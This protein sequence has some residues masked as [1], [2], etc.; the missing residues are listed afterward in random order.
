MLTLVCVVVGDG[1]PFPVEI[2]ADQSVG[3]LK[4]KIKATNP[5]SILCV[6]KD[7]D[8]YLAL[9]DNAWLESTN[10]LT[11]Q[12]IKGET[13]DEMQNYLGKVM[14]MNPFSSLD[15]ALPTRPGQ[16]QLHTLVVVP[17]R[18]AIPSDIE[19]SKKR[20]LDDLAKEISTPSLFANC[21][22]RNSWIFQLQKFDGQIQ[23]HRLPP[24]D[25]RSLLPLVLLH[26]TFATFDA[27]CKTIAFGRRDCD[28][29]VAFCNAMSDQVDAETARNMLES[30]L[31]CDSTVGGSSVLDKALYVAVETGDGGGDPTMY[32]LANYIQ[33]L[34]HKIDRAMPCYLV[35]IC[36]PLLSVF[37]IVNVAD[38]FVLCEP[39]VTSIPLL[40][41]D[42]VGL[43]TTGVRVFASLK[44]ALQDLTSSYAFT[45][46]DLNQSR[47]PY[48]DSAVIDGET[49]KIRYCK[50]LERFVFSAKVGH[51]GHEVVVK[52]AKQYGKDVHEYC[53]GLGFAPKFLYLKVLPS[54][55]IFVVMEK[56]VLQPIWD[57]PVDAII[58]REQVLEIK[59]RLA[60]A[61]L[62]HGDLRQDN[63]L[64]DSLNRRVV[65]MD[66][67]WSGKA[68]VARYPPFMNPDIPWPEGAETNKP[69]CT[70]HDEWWID[71]L[72]S[73][74][75][76]K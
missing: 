13:P 11:L 70:Q 60:D 62:V 67:D 51:S 20:K 9:K 7:L 73:N 52:F 61:K 59:N 26:E 41:F 42:N 54:N 31:H 22:G 40:F 75:E 56:L 21:R 29:F 8:L 33:H 34:P 15:E 57:A 5:N 39:L 44:A 17:E 14:R 63:I 47:F 71:R 69:L 68:G 1:S 76:K 32:N 74:L 49:A 3:D 64:W 55:W 28:F 30:Y 12:L 53:A 72:L 19:P 35:D 36:G 50:Q 4:D 6:A 27:N 18:V 38:D 65:L 37:G 66:F 58:V 46:R 2:D 16:D 25:K 45:R 43:M 23:C 10:P 24:S 48:H